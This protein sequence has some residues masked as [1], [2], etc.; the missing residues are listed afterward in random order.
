MFKKYLVIIM[1]VLSLSVVG[2]T[3]SGTEESSTGE[4][5]NRLETILDNGVMRVAMIPDNPGWSVMNAS[6]EWVG[7][8]ADVAR[9]IA[10]S[11]GVEIEFVV[12]D[13]AGRVPLIQTDKVDIVIS[14]FT[15]T[16]ER[17][18][19][20]GFT[21][22][23]ATSGILPLVRKDNML[24]SWDDL[25]DKKISV[26]R[27]STNDVFATAAF[28]DAEIVRFD[29]IADAFLAVK[30]GKVDVLLEED[31]A[32]YDLAKNNTDTVPMDVELQSSSYICMGVAQGNQIWK[33]YVD[34]VI[35]NALHSGKLNEFYK[36]NFNRE[37]P[38][39][40]IY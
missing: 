18:K 16:N 24:E 30:T 32:V 21:I 14:C 9:L 28:P 4:T 34:H 40:V 2:C 29:S 7:Y 37:L 15:A 22:P 1:V 12:T 33:N 27:G 23:Y 10:E 13:G 26:G 6:G 20:V 17:A 38:E 35:Q 25:A 19:S 39:M 3:G 8:D 11:L 36:E 31:T 5:S